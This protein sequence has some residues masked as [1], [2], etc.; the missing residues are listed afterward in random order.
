MP[1]TLASTKHFRLAQ[2]LREY[3]QRSSVGHVL[4]TVTEIM[5]QYN[6]S[7]ATVDRAF[8]RLRQEGLVSRPTGRLRYVV[9]ESSDPATVRI[10]VI[11]PDY[12]S[13]T[14]EELSRTIVA[15]GGSKNWAFQQVNYR[16]LEGLDLRRAI[17]ENDAAVLLPT[18]EP[19][20]QHLISSL[21]RPRQPVIVI[22]E[23]PPGLRVSSVAIDDVAIGQKAVDYLGSLGHRRILILLNEP[24]SPSRNLRFDGWRNQ[25][26]AIGQTD[27]QSLIIDCDLEPFENS[28]IGAYTCFKKWLA[29]PHPAFT[30]VFCPASTGAMAALRALREQGVRVPEDVSVISHGGEEQI[31]PFL[32]PALTALETDMVHYGT[33]LVKE[34]ERQL[35]DPS[36]PVRQ[37]VIPSHLVLRESVG[38]AP[39]HL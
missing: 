23:P 6:V 32:H 27:Y 22:Q 29:D 34:I 39:S 7:Q 12:P 26:H 17:G 15:A 18:S 37:A 24:S 10:A 19:F 13:P 36:A 16:S 14:Y 28:I 8:I 1:K 35:S 38:P 5:T 33:V 9:A 30:A 21:R 4:P 11:R 20:P 2:Q 25:M 31:G 3:I